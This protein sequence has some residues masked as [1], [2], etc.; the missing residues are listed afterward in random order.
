MLCLT[1]KGDD[2]GVLPLQVLCLDTAD[3]GATHFEINPGH[4][5][6]VVFLRHRCLGIT[7]LDKEDTPITEIV[8]GS[9][10]NL[11][12]QCQAV[13]AGSEAD[14]WLGAILVAEHGHVLGIHIGRIAD[15]NIETLPGISANRSDW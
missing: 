10:E 12:N 9:I 15:D 11:L 5:Q 7:D 13:I 3:T 2:R 6:K 1:C 8:H 4:G 14:L